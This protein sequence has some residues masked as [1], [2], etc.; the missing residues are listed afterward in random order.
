VRRHA[1]LLVIAL[2]VLF[3]V[4][5]REFFRGEGGSNGPRQEVG[6]GPGA[7][8]VRGG[9]AGE[10]GTAASE[11]GREP[12][13]PGEG[14]LV[15]GWV[16]DSGL[17]PLAGC[18]V[19]VRTEGIDPIRAETDARG[20]FRLSV[21][22]SP[23]VGR[24]YTL[25]ARDGAGRVGLIFAYGTG[26]RVLRAQGIV[27]REAP[28]LQVRVLD[29]GRPV[30]GARVLVFTS[31]PHGV[32]G[33]G[34]LPLAEAA[35]G[36]DGI[37][38]FGPVPE[39]GLVILA[40]SETTRRGVIGLGFTAEETEPVEV[41]L[42][43]ARSIRVEVV[44]AETGAPI[45]GLRIHTVYVLPEP[46]PPTDG[47][48]RT[49]VSGA[50]PAEVL[51]L[52][53][54]GGA[55]V[56]VPPR[57]THCRISF[58]RPSGPEPEGES[59]LLVRLL[60]PSGEPAPDR[61]VMLDV[62]GNGTGR[63]TDAAG[64]A[65]FPKLPRA[66][67]PVYLQGAGGRVGLGVAR[68]DRG[69]ERL[70]VRLHP[71]ILVSARVRVD[72]RERLPPRFGLSVSRAL[73]E[74]L[75]VSPGDGR[76]E[77]SV[78]PVTAI[79]ELEVTL[80]ANGYVPD[81]V[82]LPVAPRTG[83][84]FLLQRRGALT[85][86]YATPPDGRMELRLERRGEDGSWSGNR[87]TRP[88][89]PAPGLARFSGLAHGTY[90][91]VDLLSGIVSPDVT[92]AP[93]LPDVAVDM[94]L[95]SLVTVSGR[96]EIPSG[97]ERSGTG[98]EV[99]CEGV[100]YGRQAEVDEDGEFSVRVPGDRV[101]TLTASHPVYEPDPERGTVTRTGSAS[102]VVLVLSV[103]RQVTLD[104]SP[105]L[106]EWRR[107]QTRI[108]LFEGEPGPDPD[109]VLRFA[110]AGDR[111]TLAG[112]EPGTWTLFVDV[113]GSAPVLRREVRIGE[114]RSHLGRIALEAGGGIRI[115]LRT[116]EGDQP[117]QIFVESRF[118]GEP[119]YVRKDNSWGV[120]ELRMAGLGPGRHRVEVR[121]SSEKRRKSLVRE[122][123]S[124]GAGEIAIEVD[125][126][127]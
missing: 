44:G 26:Q 87:W 49:L 52:R 91:V 48:G 57:V 77:F 76:L 80:V 85:V 41:H 59:T 88:D 4:A 13:L 8:P 96:V 5:L 39:S 106:P 38:S 82:T 75:D 112:A 103:G 84:E 61:R 102:G 93:D 55:P 35:S 120:R 65:V 92:V 83:A 51:T 28:E 19:S 34:S 121:A 21:P 42:G 3:A 33:R 117:E 62:F 74:I 104:L 17:T 12:V 6:D 126:T 43:P 63:V 31:D 2:L 32:R 15:T 70:E 78:L 23:E 127:D 72:G 9:P 68:L 86:R 54:E 95:G 66:A 105:E 116:K 98:V 11:S 100:L 99:R 58:E 25:V 111:L 79:R 89:R 109:V 115:R 1:I 123:E 67:L 10:S 22:V 73:V 46:I 118:L 30:P 20:L 122:V 81:R 36:G 18:H 108:L 90:R 64:E 119:S 14:V 27:I 71:E 45:S 29:E 24:I 47:S 16:V 97:G 94:D 69:Q 101:V 37:A 110:V 53:P 113:P 60:G 7:P 50:D 124:D 107:R 114:G 125:L 40:F 56:V